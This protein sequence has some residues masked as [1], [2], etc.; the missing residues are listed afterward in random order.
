[1]DHWLLQRLAWKFDDIHVQL[2]FSLFWIWFLGLSVSTSSS[3]Y[4]SFSSVCCFCCCLWKLSLHKQWVWGRRPSH[5]FITF[6]ITLI[7]PSFLLFSYHYEYRIISI[8]RIFTSRFM[9]A[10]NFCGKLHVYL[11]IWSFMWVFLVLTVKCYVGFYILLKR[12]EE[13]DKE[14]RNEAIGKWE[15]EFYLHCRVASVRPK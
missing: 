6:V 11:S 9:S 13:Y 2:A 5:L 10:Y 7:C 1:M 12:I 8:T 15:G 3:I 4:V 14:W